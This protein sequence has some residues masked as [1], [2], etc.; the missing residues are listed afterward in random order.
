[1]VP[2]T[3]TGGG[4][5]PPR[6]HYVVM[7]AARISLWIGSYPAPAGWDLAAAGSEWPEALLTLAPGLARVCAPTWMRGSVEALVGKVERDQGRRV[8]VVWRS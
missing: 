7:P 4:G 8:E 1:M 5:H 6:A 2:A 3:A